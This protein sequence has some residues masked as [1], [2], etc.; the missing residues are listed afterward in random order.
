MGPHPKGPLSSYSLE[1][2]HYVPGFPP[3]H[4]KNEKGKDSRVRFYRAQCIQC[5]ELSIVLRLHLL[6][7]WSSKYMMVRGDSSYFQCP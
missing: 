2:V 1:Q 5:K 3:V 4:S 7:F 6:A